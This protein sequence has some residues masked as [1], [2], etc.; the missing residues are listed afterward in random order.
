MTKELDRTVLFSQQTRD[1]L[2]EFPEDATPLGEFEIRG[3]NAKIA[4][5]ALD[6]EAPA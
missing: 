5:W 6:V 3:R 2:R 4:L 1:A